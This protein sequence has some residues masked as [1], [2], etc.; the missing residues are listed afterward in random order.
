MG[1]CNGL[2]SQCTDGEDPKAL[3]RDQVSS[4]VKKNN[5]MKRGARP[6][7]GAA[8]VVSNKDFEKY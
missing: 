4:E 2:C 5:G 1:N 6:M 3:N 7:A 8:A